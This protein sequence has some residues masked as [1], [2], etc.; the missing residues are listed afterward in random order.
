[1]NQLRLTLFL[2]LLLLSRFAPAADCDGVVKD[3]SAKSQAILRDIRAKNGF[4][5]SAWAQLADPPADVSIHATPWLER[6]E[7]AGAS[8]VHLSR[9]SAQWSCQGSACKI[10][11][12]CTLWPKTSVDAQKVVSLHERAGVH[13]LNDHHYDGSLR[14]W[15]LS[16]PETDH[17]LTAGEKRSIEKELQV[18][19]GITGVGGGGDTG[20]VTPQVILLRQDLLRLKGVTDP[21]E[22]A[23]LFK[24]LQQ[25]FS[26]RTEVHRLRDGTVL[27]SYS[28]APLG[29]GVDVNRIAACTHFLQISHSEQ[30]D[31][32]NRLTRNDLNV[33]KVIPDFEALVSYC[34]K[35]VGQ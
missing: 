19:G 15:L 27:E 2:S 25:D 9:E 26:I 20:G 22:R 21:S 3:F 11:V 34:K 28:N 1:M 29:R 32:F 18:A 16:L 30:M 7:D 12:N 35:A 8:V 14:Y 4:I 10:E 33:Q 23:T 17:I 24:R 13:H 5:H 31:F 6:P